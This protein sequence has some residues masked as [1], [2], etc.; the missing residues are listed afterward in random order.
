MNSKTCFFFITK[1]AG[2]VFCLKFSRSCLNKRHLNTHYYQYH[3]E[4]RD[5]TK[6]KV[7]HFKVNGRAT[8]DKKQLF[9]HVTLILNTIISLK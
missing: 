1:H 3:F 9:S 6:K 7:H 5:V 8:G 2:A 4:V